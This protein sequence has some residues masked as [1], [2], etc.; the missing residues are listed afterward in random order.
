MPTVLVVDD[1]T[2]VR[3][4]LRIFL[5][6]LGANALEAPDGATAIEL[7]R[8][9]AGSIDLVLL[10]L[11]LPDV[12]GTEVLAALRQINPEVCCIFATGVAAGEL[13]GLGAEV[14]RKP[15]RLADLEESC[16]F[17]PTSPPGRKLAIDT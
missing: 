8:Q 13:A 10:D 7:Y 14:L 4:L 12:K 16:G 9:H 17:T 11:N 6:R 15:L 5:S 1:E 3:Q 2:P